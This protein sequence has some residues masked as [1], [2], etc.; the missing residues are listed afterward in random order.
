MKI[1]TLNAPHEHDGREYPAGAELPPL[2]DATADWLI[3][4][5]KASATA[6]TRAKADATPKAAEI[7]QNKEQA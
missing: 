6:S 4:I 3:E 5:G 7:T 1:V 2:D